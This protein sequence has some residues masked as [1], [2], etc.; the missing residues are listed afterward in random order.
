MIS[1]AISHHPHS[2]APGPWT[3][4]QKHYAA[5][6]GS[7]DTEAANTIGQVIDTMTGRER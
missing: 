2:T 7:A 4:F 6:A 5:L 1:R 3:V